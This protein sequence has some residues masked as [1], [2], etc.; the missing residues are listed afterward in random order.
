MY[1]ATQPR[2]V[3]ERI[4]TA[5]VMRL[6]R[7]QAR[8]RATD[9]RRRPPIEPSPRGAHPAVEGGADGAL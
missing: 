7:C 2:I 5:Q 6:E 3:R 1:H 4:I 9:S 8:A